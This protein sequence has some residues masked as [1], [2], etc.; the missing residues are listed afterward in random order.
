MELPGYDSIELNLKNVDDIQHDGGKIV[1]FILFYFILF[2]FILLSIRDLN[3]LVCFVLLR[4]DIFYISISNSDTR[5]DIN[6]N[7]RYDTRILTRRI[8]FR[9]YNQIP[10]KKE[11]IP[12]IRHWWRWNTQ[13]RA[14]VTFVHY[15]CTYIIEYV[16]YS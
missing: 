7:I 11:H 1:Y 10:S 6:Y 3:N 4:C 8:R 14:Y 15:V 2:Y 13:V 16:H 5:F 12:T 9:Y